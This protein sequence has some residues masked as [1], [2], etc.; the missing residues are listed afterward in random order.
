MSIFQDDELEPIFREERLERFAIV[1]WNDFSGRRDDW[2]NT[3]FAI[4][5]GEQIPR[6]TTYDNLR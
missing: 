5:D 2:Y 6:T 3:V 4:Y 1:V